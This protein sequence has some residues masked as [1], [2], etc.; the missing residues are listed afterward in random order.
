MARRR[1]SCACR[2]KRQKSRR[3][4]KGQKKKKTCKRQ[5]I[6]KNNG[7]D[8]MLSHVQHCLTKDKAR[9]QIVING[10]STAN[11]VSKFPGSDETGTYVSQP[12]AITKENNL[13]FVARL[14]NICFI[15]IPCTK[16]P[17]PSEGEQQPLEIANSKI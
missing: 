16:K 14:E 17:P 15:A 13:C 9:L 2:S 10:L 7:S 4:K 1:K 5:L 6:S 8:D 11:E 12:P 3:C